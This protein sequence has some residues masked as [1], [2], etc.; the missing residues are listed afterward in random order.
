MFT[1]HGFDMTA[2][3]IKIKIK[4]IHEGCLELASPQPC[5]ADLGVLS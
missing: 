1:N 2:K 4:I 3:V 5:R